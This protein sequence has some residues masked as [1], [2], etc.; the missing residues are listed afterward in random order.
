M[1]YRVLLLQTAS[2]IG[3]DIALGGLP[4][5]GPQSG[6]A[7]DSAGMRPRYRLAQPPGEGVVVEVKLRG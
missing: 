1:T 3:I 2:G 7:L 6:E 5:E 4:M